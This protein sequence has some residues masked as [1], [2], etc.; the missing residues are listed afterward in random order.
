MDVG[1]QLIN[2]TKQY[3]NSPMFLSGLFSPLPTHNLKRKRSTVLVLFSSP[4]SHSFPISLFPGLLSFWLL[5]LERDFSGFKWWFQQ[6]FFAASSERREK[7]SFLLEGR[8]ESMELL[9]LLLS[10][11]FS[12]AL[13]DEGTML[14]L[15]GFGVSFLFDTN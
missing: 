5:L 9:L 3:K 15:P 2:G 6:V 14:L 12:V 8:K 1:S 13:A 7:E 4:L 11:A 10:V